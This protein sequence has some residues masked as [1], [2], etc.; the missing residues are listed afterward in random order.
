MEDV[1]YRLFYKSRVYADLYSVYLTLYINNVLVMATMCY[2]STFISLIN[3]SWYLLIII[4]NRYMFFTIY[5]RI[6]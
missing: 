3:L 1:L 6:T 2:F 4:I 5:R